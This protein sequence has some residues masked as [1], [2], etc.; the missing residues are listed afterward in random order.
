MNNYIKKNNKNNEAWQ[1]SMYIDIFYICHT[2]I[3][4]TLN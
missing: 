3:F 1:H 4:Q 2:F